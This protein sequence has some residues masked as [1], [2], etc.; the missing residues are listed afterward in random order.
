V[1]PV[2]LLAT[3]VLLLVLVDPFLART[4]GFALSVLATGAIVVVAPNWTTALGRWMSPGAAAALA[5][6]AAAQLACTPVLVA[7]F[8]QATPWAVPANLLAAPAVAPTTV[9]GIVTAAVATVSPALASYVAGLAALPAAWLATVARS[10]AALPGADARWPTGVPGLL[11]LA[12]TAAGGVTAV[13]VARN[14]HRL[15]A[16]AI[17]ATWPR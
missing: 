6:P 17:L 11:L 9:L 12:A 5:V 8:G 13:A 4:V 15:R 10:M 7:V 3:A 2:P 1:S 14:R 16:H